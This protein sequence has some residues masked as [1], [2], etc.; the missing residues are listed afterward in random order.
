MAVVTHTPGNP[1]AALLRAVLQ[2][3]RGVPA[4]RG[5]E[6]LR[7]RSRGSSPYRAA[8]DPAAIQHSAGVRTPP[9]AGARVLAFHFPSVIDLR[10][11]A[12]S[13][14]ARVI[15]SVWRASRAVAIGHGR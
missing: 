8:P 1:A 15:S 4:G 5:P 6:R 3:T 9:A 13:S 10:V 7:P 12:D 14:I 11:R 2:D